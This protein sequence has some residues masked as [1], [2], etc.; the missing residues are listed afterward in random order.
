MDTWHDVGQVVKMWIRLKEQGFWGIT[1]LIF[2]LGGKNVRE[3][4][5][6]E[7]KK[8]NPTLFP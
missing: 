8:E 2:L 5:K 1:D 6:R 7:R 3:R 4:A